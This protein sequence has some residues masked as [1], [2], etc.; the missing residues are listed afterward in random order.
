[1]GATASAWETLQDPEKRQ[2]SLTALQ[3][4]FQEKVREWV[5]KGEMTEQEARNFVDSFL[6]QPPGSSTSSPEYP[7]EQ[8]PEPTGSGDAQESLEELTSQIADLRSELENLRHSSH[9]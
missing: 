9:Q 1:L 4:E 3:A 5:A 2:E 6:K 8:Q 7:P